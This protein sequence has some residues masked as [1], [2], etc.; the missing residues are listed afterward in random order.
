MNDKEKL[1]DKLV[2]H[3][4]NSVYPMHMPG[5]KRNTKLMNM[6]NPYAID[7]TEIDGFDNMHNPKEVIKNIEDRANN[8]YGSKRTWLSVNG[9]SIGLMAAICAVTN[10]GDSILIG[11]NSHKSIYNAI[12]LNELN[13]EYIYPEYIGNGINGQIFLTD[14]INK[15]ENNPKICAVVI[16]SPTYEGVISDIAGISKYLHSKG[17]PLIVDAAHGAHFGFDANF[18][19]NA[20][21]CGADIVVHSIHKTLPAFTQTSLLH[22]CSDKLVDIN[23]V[24]KYMSIFQSS[25]PSYILMSG[26]EKCIDIMEHSEELFKKYNNYLDYFYEETKKLNNIYIL[27]YKDGNNIWRDKSK[28]VICSKCED[29]KNYGGMYIY[30]QL[31]RQYNIQLEMKSTSYALAMTSI[32]DTK[33]GFDRLLIALVN[34]DKELDKIGVKIKENLGEIVGNCVDNVDNRNVEK[35]RI[36]ADWDDLPIAFKSYTHYPPYKIQKML[37]TT[38]LLEGSVDKISAE[39]VYLYPPDIPLIVPGEII[40]QEFINIIN[41]Y[42][43]RGFGIEGLQDE[44]AE[45]INIIDED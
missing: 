44:K 18:P 16:T 40:T 32:C 43:K 26:I 28:I 14:I 27:D 10:K 37:I 12:E 9:S 2:E 36:Y 19:Q 42:K 22:V 17:I 31:L 15:I 45:Y 41:E 33:E 23:R 29:D 25:S 6:T 1:Y 8:L 3:N 11:R 13:P 21:N 34:I 20:I 30:T 38:V 7:I 4:E 5:H 35:A 39:Y 24:N